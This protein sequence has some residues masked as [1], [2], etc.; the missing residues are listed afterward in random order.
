MSTTLL[1]SKIQV[2]SLKLAP[3]LNWWFQFKVWFTTDFWCLICI[4]KRRAGKKSTPWEQQYRDGPLMLPPMTHAGM[5]P[6]NRHIAWY[7]AA[8]LYDIRYMYKFCRMRTWADLCDCFLWDQTIPSAHKSI[9]MVV[10]RVVAW[11]L[12]DSMEMPK[13]MH[14]PVL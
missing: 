13:N 8:S 1:L 4:I 2:I 14:L 9:S 10:A 5:H 6:W 12:S 3:H 11:C 7:M